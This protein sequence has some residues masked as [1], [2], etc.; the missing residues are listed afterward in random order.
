MRTTLKDSRLGRVIRRMGRQTLSA[1]K[2]TGLRLFLAR[3]ECRAR[4]AVPVPNIQAAAGTTAMIAH[5]FYA[6]LLDEILA[7]H[8]LLPA[9][10]PLHL[11]APAPVAAALAPRIGALP[12]A[13]LH[14][15]ENRGRDIAPFLTVLRSGMLDAY[16]A[17]LKL[18]TKRSPH[19]GHGDLLR[20]A[21]FSSLAGYP[22]SVGR[23][24]RIIEDPS[25]GMVGWRQ[26]FMTSPRHWYTNRSRVESLAMALDPP[27]EPRLAFFGGSMFWFRPDALRSIA[28]LDIGPEDFEPEAG[29]I[30]GT[31]HHALER[32]FAISAAARGYSVVDTKGAVLLAAA[33]SPGAVKKRASRA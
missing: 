18:H 2:A 33:T 12:H 5:V 3:E 11:T 26:V 4:M 7:C 30:D 6:D 23:I 31:L 28:A 22:E 17:V 27:A 24:L 29:Q 1:T 15:V 21:L 19:L 13:V 10:T 16:P 32:C 9:G 25:V 20:R 14:T 8:A